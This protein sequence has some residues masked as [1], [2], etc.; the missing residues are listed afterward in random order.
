M[1]RD[2]NCPSTMEYCTKC[3]NSKTFV[4]ML[5]SMPPPFPPNKTGNQIHKGLVPKGHNLTPMWW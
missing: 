5:I 3:G 4:D 2:T 1:T